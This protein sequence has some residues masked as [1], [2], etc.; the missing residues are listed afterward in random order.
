MLDL[1]QLDTLGRGIFSSSVRNDRYS[2]SAGGSMFYVG[3][4]RKGYGALNDYN[5]FAT[6]TVASHTLH[7]YSTSPI[8]A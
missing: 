8:T 7:S 3:T 6:A 2:S 1:P 4:A 5:V